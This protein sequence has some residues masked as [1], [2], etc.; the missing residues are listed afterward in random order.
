MRSLGTALALCLAW[1]LTASAQTAERPAI[2][3][4]LGAGTGGEGAWTCSGAAHSPTTLKVDETAGPEATPAAVLEF[5]FSPGKYN[6]NWAEVACGSARATGCVAVRLTYRTELPD[7]FP[8]LNLMV[9]EST[10][11]GYWVPDCLP[12][13]PTRFRTETVAFTRFTVPSWSKDDNGKL[14]LELV[15]H[16]ALGLATGSS[17][18]GRILIADVELVPPGW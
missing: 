1:P 5:T 6:Y 18:P 16:V 9:R 17:G 2:P 10:G 11:A 14:D 4:T 3:L 15:D 12:P 8:A 7:G 13:S